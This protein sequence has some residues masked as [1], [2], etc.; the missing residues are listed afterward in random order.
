MANDS[1]NLYNFIVKMHPSTPGS[2]DADSY[3]EYQ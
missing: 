3:W 1:F 2:Q